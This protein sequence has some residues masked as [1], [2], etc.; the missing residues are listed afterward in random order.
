MSKVLVFEFDTDNPNWIMGF[1]AG[2]LWQRLQDG[3]TI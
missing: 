3:D 2:S 1:E